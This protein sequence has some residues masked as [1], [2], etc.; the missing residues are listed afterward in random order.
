MSKEIKIV[1]LGQEEVEVRDAIPIFY[2]GSF[3]GAYERYYYSEEKS[4]LFCISQNEDFGVEALNIASAFKQLMEWK[5]NQHPGRICREIAEQNKYQITVD[6]LDDE[7]TERTNMENKEFWLANDGEDAD[8]P[9]HLIFKEDCKLVAYADCTRGTDDHDDIYRVK[10]GPYAGKLLRNYASRWQSSPDYVA[11]LY[12]SEGEVPDFK[13][14][15]KAEAY[16]KSEIRIEIDEAGLGN[17]WHAGK[18]ELKKIAEFYEE[19][20]TKQFPH[21]KFNVIPIID[22]WNGAHPSE[23][24]DNTDAW[25]RALERAPAE[26]WQ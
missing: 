13:N 25:E 16:K 6:E 19:E 10:S 7:Y 22:S 8:F 3:R 11:T 17:T 23:F 12:E 9:R 4:L 21:Y 15:L 24:E 5:G 14:Y 18:A 20:L 2:D 1:K 26:W